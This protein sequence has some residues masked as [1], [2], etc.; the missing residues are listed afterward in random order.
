MPKEDEELFLF[1]SLVAGSAG[2]L[3]ILGDFKPSEGDRVCGNVSEGTFEYKL[4]HFV[5]EWHGSTRSPRDQTEIR[6]SIF[7]PWLVAN[8]NTE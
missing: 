5:H 4:L 8:E 7:D 3:Y 1:F 2:K 6:A